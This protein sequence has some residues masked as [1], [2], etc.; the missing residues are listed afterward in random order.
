MS[1]LFT[2][3]L[4]FLVVLAVVAVVVW[5]YSYAP[6]PTR[7]RKLAHQL[8]EAPDQLDSQAHRDLQMMAEQ[9]YP[10]LQKMLLHRHWQIRRTAIQALAYLETREQSAQKSVQD[11]LHDQE[12]RVRKMAA[13]A[14]G[15]KGWYSASAV[16]SMAQA[17]VREKEWQVRREIAQALG[18]IGPAAQSAVEALE[19]KLQDS[20]WSVRTASL[21]ALVRIHLW[22]QR[23]LPILEQT[24]EDPHWQVRE[25]AAQLGSQ[26]GLAA[27]A[28]VPQ[29]QK[30]TQDSE[31]SVRRAATATLQHLAHRTLARSLSSAQKLRYHRAFDEF[32]NWTPS[33]RLLLESTLQALIRSDL[34]GQRAL[35]NVLYD[36][37]YEA[38]ENADN[39]NDSDSDSSRTYASI[40]PLLVAVIQATPRLGKLSVFALPCI[41]RLLES[42][43]P[44]V[45]WAAAQ[46]LARIPSPLP[47]LRELLHNQDPW[48]QLEAAQVGQQLGTKAVLIM[49]EALTHPHHQIRQIATQALGQYHQHQDMIIKPLTRKLHD[50]IEQVRINAARSLLQF[51]AI[52]QNA[53]L[54]ELNQLPLIQLTLLLS[55]IP[56]LPAHLLSSRKQGQLLVA[57]MNMLRTGESQERMQA[58]QALIPLGGQASPL[59]PELRQLFTNSNNIQVRRAVAHALLS[60]GKHRPEAIEPLRDALQHPSQ[61][62]QHLALQTLHQLGSQ[63]TIAIPQL[64]QALQHANTRRL[65]MLTLLKM[66]PSLV[67]SL[68]PW[69]QHSNIQVR[70]AVVELLAAQDNLGAEGISLL[71]QAS[72]DTAPLVQITAQRA[73]QKHQSAQK[74]TPSPQAAPTSRPAPT[75]QPTQR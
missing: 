3:T 10:T 75:S 67:P 47:T 74:T 33:S 73:L 20:D 15:Q 70:W 66:G 14:L 63:A 21:R 1:K 24:L 59:L 4:M 51:A 30:S 41:H 18:Q 44:E 48:V 7:I 35:L 72:S 53:L 69:L 50:P 43:E 26:I 6:L 71:Q 61:D 65:A 42:E 11:A 9:A 34:P 17:L 38:N 37:E 64:L 45:R 28:L 52:G 58:A 19:M 56:E 12:W 29:L 49:L 8:A 27:M 22:P 68:K 31:P 40:S 36:L 62:I 55:K 16:Q 54:Q 25:Q 60:L 46:A 32:K 2:R 39:D 23:L 5:S 57:L 13:F